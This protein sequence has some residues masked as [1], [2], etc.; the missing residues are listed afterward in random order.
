MF[1]EREKTPTVPEGVNVIDT[2]Q[3]VIPEGVAKEANIQQV[4]TAASA[5]IKVGG[6]QA[7]QTPQDQTITITLPSDPQVLMQQTK[8]GNIVDALTWFA[9]Y[10]L[11]MVKKAAHFGWKVI[12][13]TQ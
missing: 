10:W 13:K 2:E 7:I 5:N 1:T 12:V 4:E 9:A 3:K 6:Q 8:K 11:R